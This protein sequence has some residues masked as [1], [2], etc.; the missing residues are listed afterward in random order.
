[1]LPPAFEFDGNLTQTPLGGKMAPADAPILSHDTRA[2]AE[3]LLDDLWY[4]L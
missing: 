1:L 2:I 4:C 3:A